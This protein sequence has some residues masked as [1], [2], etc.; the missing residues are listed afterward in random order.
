MDKPI[1]R[2]VFIGI[3]IALLLAAF[4]YAADQQSTFQNTSI[5][6]TDQDAYI[7]YMRRMV[8]NNYRYTDG[9]RA[10]L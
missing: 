9:S 6:L 8:D 2:I 1:L 10:P 3:I 4:L 7:L 5:S